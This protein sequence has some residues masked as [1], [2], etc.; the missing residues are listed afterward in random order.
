MIKNTLSHRHHR[1]YLVLSSASTSSSFAAN[2]PLLTQPAAHRHHYHRWAGPTLDRLGEAN[3]FRKV[4][5][6]KSG[7]F[8]PGP[9]L[10]IPTNP[11][12]VVTKRKTAQVHRLHPGAAHGASPRSHLPVAP[13]DFGPRLRSHLLTPR[14]QSEQRV[15]TPHVSPLS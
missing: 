9:T 14:D 12:F 8:S 15:A 10:F 6:I 13:D 7:H 1:L 11:S 5:Q 2:P 3:G 4:E